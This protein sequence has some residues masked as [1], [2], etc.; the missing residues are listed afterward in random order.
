[1]KFLVDVTNLSLNGDAIHTTRQQLPENLRV[2]FQQTLRPE[3]IAFLQNSLSPLSSTLI[4]S[5]QDIQD[6]KHGLVESKLIERYEELT[7]SIRD[8]KENMKSAKATQMRIE[9][10]LAGKVPEAQQKFICAA[11][12]EPAKLDTND[13]HSLDYSTGSTLNQ[14][15]VHESLAEV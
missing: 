5:H 11:E 15:T 3:L 4:Q 8:L 2:A 7:T 10:C 13:A 14:G 6:V 12:E 1:M 9:S